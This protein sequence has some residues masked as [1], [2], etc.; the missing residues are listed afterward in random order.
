VKV[1]LSKKEAANIIAIKQILEG[2]N[3]RFSEKCLNRRAGLVPKNATG[4]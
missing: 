1:P 2:A 3:E 4:H